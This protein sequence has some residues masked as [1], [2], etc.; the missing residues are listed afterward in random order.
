MYTLRNNGAAWFVENVL[1]ANNTNEEILLLDSLDTQ[2]TAVIRAD[3]LEKLPTQNISRDSTASIDITRHEPN[4]LVYETATQTDQLAV[5]SEMYYPKGWNAYIDGKP[6]EYFRANYVLRAMVIPAGIHT[7]DF[8][9]EPKVI[10]TGSTYSLISF[11]ILILVAV[12]GLF[13]IWKQRKNQTT[14]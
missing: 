2:K 3:F 8:K 7:I 1:P 6:A 9:F 12:T 10:S 14:S 11:I 5:F 13:F 4:H